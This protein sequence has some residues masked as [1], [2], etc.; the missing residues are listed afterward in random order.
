MFGQ[1]ILINA[2]MYD[3]FDQ[4]SDA[5]W[6]LVDGAGKQKYYIPGS[7]YVLISCSNS[8]KIIELTHPKTPSV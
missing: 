3:Y 4:P 5:A 2:C 8:F 6:F 1:E 7:K